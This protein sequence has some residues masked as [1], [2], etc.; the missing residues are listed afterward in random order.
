[1]AT[2]KPNLDSNGDEIGA[3]NGPKSRVIV[4]ALDALKVGK[5]PDDQK[6][7]VRKLKR[8]AEALLG[9]RGEP[10]GGA[11]TN[12]ALT[13]GMWVVRAD[14]DDGEETD[15]VGHV[16]FVWADQWAGRLWRGGTWQLVTRQQSEWAEAENVEREIADAL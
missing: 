4:E 15:M 11:E 14:L 5:L 12:P 8:A 9:V 16:D 3:D 10:V 7:V 13:V 2:R 6:P 1:M